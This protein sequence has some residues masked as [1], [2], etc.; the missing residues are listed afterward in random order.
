MKILITGGSGFIASHLCKQLIKDGHDVTLLSRDKNKCVIDNVIEKSIENILITDIKDFD[1]IY[2]CAAN[3]NRK[4][5]LN[6]HTK[7]IDVNIK[8]TNGLFERVRYM[9]NEH[10]KQIKVIYISSFL[11]TGKCEDEICTENSSP[12]PMDMY[13]ISKLTGEYISKMYNEVFGLDIRIVRLTNVIGSLPQSN[14]IN[15]VISSILKNNSFNI[16]GKNK[17]R[18]FIYIDDVISGL[19]AVAKYG[20]KSKIYYIGNDKSYTFEYIINTIVKKFG[21]NPIIKNILEPQYSKDI[22]MINYNCDISEMIKLG[23]RP[24]INIEQIIDN[25]IDNWR[26]NV[27]S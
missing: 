18:N 6:N 3:I 13:S 22:D 24:Q 9:H 17:S 4:P 14:L 8:A 10:K 21:T 7:D 27:K 12:K 19:I 1:I 25:M 23:W 20:K 26:I 2:H 16:F 15:Y 5:Y 11:V